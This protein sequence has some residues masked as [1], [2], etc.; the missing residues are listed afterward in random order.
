MSKPLAAG[1]SLSIEY[2]QWQGVRA[3][4]NDAPVGAFLGDAAVTV[5]AR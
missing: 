5:A 3:F 1:D 4:I 2:L